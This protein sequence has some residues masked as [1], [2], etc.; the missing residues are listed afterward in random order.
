M[1][2]AQH[3]YARQATKDHLEEQADAAEY[4]RRE[5]NERNDRRTFLH[6]ALGK[7]SAGVEGVLLHAQTEKIDRRECDNMREEPGHAGKQNNCGDTEE[8]CDAKQ[9]RCTVVCSVMAR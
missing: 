6:P 3:E 9:D 7:Y 2:R 5:R 8:C 4:T 1:D